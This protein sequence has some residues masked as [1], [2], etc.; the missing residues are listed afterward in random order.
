MQDFL[1]A[2]R[3]VKKPA[4]DVYEACEWTAVALLSSLS[5]SNRGRAMDMPNF[6]TNVM[7]EKTLKL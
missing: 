2:V 5:V 1:D 4:V 7:K 3:G 6:R